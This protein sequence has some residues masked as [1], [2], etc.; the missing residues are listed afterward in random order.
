[1]GRITAQVSALLFNFFVIRPG[2]ARLLFPGSEERFDLFVL[3][4]YAGTAQ[5]SAVLVSAFSEDLA[6]PLKCTR[7]K[8]PGVIFLVGFL[9]VCLAIEIRY[10]GSGSIC[11]SAETGWGWDD[12]GNTTCT[13]VS[14]G[15]SPQPRLGAAL[16]S[17]VPLREPLAS[18][19]RDAPAGRGVDRS[20]RK[21]S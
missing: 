1:M 4:V 8:G 3:V 10:T 13:Y 2:C 15:L 16:P 21:A 12:Q 14:F 17:I 5:G 9:F 20:E 7:L 6:M 11:Q 19:E 18:P